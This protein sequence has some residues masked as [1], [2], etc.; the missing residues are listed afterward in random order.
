MAGKSPNRHPQWD[1]EEEPGFA[2]KI[3]ESSWLFQECAYVA[4]GGL[5]AVNREAG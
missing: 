2:G 3:G 5:D 1:F 4:S